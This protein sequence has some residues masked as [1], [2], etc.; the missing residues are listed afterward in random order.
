MYHRLSGAPDKTDNRALLAMFAARKRVFVDL[1][2]WELPVVSERYEIDQ[3]DTPDA[4]YLVLEGEAGKHRASARLLPTSRPHILGSLFPQLSEDE[5]PQGRDI[6]E[7][8]RFCLEPG[9]GAKGRRGAR[10]ELVHALVHH[11]LCCGIRRYTGVAQ[12]GWLKQILAFG[13]RCQT[14][15]EPRRVGPVILGALVID[16]DADT[17]ALLEAAG[18]HASARDREEVVHAA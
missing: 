9:L 8:T 14:L 15:G 5:V 11:A 13:W 16:I 10:D 3:F 6:A 7:I 1:L 12:A 17:P 18:I 2:R 4:A